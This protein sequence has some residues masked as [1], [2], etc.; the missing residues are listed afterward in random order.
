MRRTSLVASASWALLA[1]ACGSEPD[2]P[3]PSGDDAGRADAGGTDARIP[4]VRAGVRCVR[5]G[6]AAPP[7]TFD[8]GPDTPAGGGAGDGGPDAGDAGSVAR[9]H[10]SLPQIATQGGGRLVSPTVIPIT[11]GHDDFADEIEDFVAS[12]G[13]TAWWR[14]VARDYGVGDAVS[15]APVRRPESFPALV[16]DAV[17]Q[18]WL[19]QNVASGVL[20]QPDDGTL[21]AVFVNAKTTVTLDGIESCSAFGGYH[22]SF[23]LD[24]RHAAYAVIPRC[25][26]F[27][28]LAGFDVVSGAASHE[29]IEAATDPYPRTAPA[30][31]QPDDA[32]VVW[33]A[34]TGGEVADMCAIAETAF[35]T[36]KG[37]P[38]VV[39]R[40]WS[41]QAASLGQ[42]PCVPAASASY[43]N[44]GPVLR[45]TLSLTGPDDRT[46]STR[47]AKIP[48]K[49]SATIDVALFGD[50]AAP[51][52]TVTPQDL[53]S[54]LG[55]T[56][57]L[58]FALDR[59]TGVAG[60]VLHLTIFRESRNKE[61]GVEAFVLVSSFGPTRNFFF[62]LVGDP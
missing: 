58:T 22:D 39:Q 32:H 62:G 42:D 51:A 6:A 40:S 43:F 15:G 37:Y 54:A 1:V 49:G 12:F 45:D 36:P 50:A 27:G 38:F 18:K 17:I 11:F 46:I 13:C 9:V 25:D 60:D 59:S 19:R 5:D 23:D 44:A 2:A 31:A 52:W 10:P 29:F 55:S 3:E 53:S 33:A 61:G 16:D 7:E 35:Y 8:A 57:R 48:V 47:G 24:G 34:V 21:Y 41:N 26:Q 28:P 30:F 14:A 4:Y 20:P 56:G